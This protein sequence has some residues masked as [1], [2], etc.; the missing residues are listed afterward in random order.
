MNQP[1]SRTVQGARRLREL[2]RRSCWFAVT[3]FLCAWIPAQERPADALLTGDA[4]RF[5]A[6]ADPR[7]RGEA[8]LAA[9]ASGAQRLLPAILRVAADE[10]PRAK[11]MGLLAL[12]YLGAPGTESFLLAALPK[13][14]GRADESAL[15]AA[16]ALARLPASSGSACLNQRLSAATE[17]SYKREHD[18][19]LALLSGLLDRGGN[20]A[21]ASIERLARDT[22][23]RD[24]HVRAAA[25]TA[26]ARSPKILG[27]GI[28]DPALRA[29]SPLVRC[30][31]LSALSN[32]PEAVRA[33]LSDLV[34]TVRIDADPQ[35]RAAALECLTANRHLPALE[36]ASRA[37][38]S[39]DPDE[40]GP[41]LV[42]ALRLGGDPSR[43]AIAR[44][45]SGLGSAA[46]R[47]YLENLS[48][49]A[50]EELLATCHAAA[51]DPR[52]DEPTRHAALLALM[53]MGQT[54][55]SEVVIR[56]FTEA[57]WPT[58]CAIASV[59]HG[60]ALAHELLAATTTHAGRSGSERRATML[61][62]LML[63]ATPG[64]NLYCAREL[65]LEEDAH[66]AS[67]AMRALRISRLPPL[68]DEARRCLPA[69]L[70]AHL[71]P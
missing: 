47:R 31:A 2:A 16:F 17:A 15:A 43:R 10:E 27:Q 51:T 69:A 50:P 1:T 26:L 18:I 59:V 33:R 29:S 54:V 68:R 62:A 3:A 44:Q 63:A 65:A 64:A 9:A 48:S 71:E 42:P 55:S 13:P 32:H 67:T 30:A 40:A 36:L 38:R 52:R 20:D 57:A 5:L 24:P 21:E 37:M 34:E 14:G 39:T 45:F 4:E 41:G 12:G 53:R 28:L 49:P 46:Q 19:L 60:D 58:Q 25:L 56:A 22:S 7:L 23:L 6:H 11:T 70:R 8:A 35:V 66:A 61:A